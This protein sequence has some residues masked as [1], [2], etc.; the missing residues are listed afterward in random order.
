MNPVSLPCAS[1]T[2]EGSPARGS[3]TKVMTSPDP[4]P[5][6][7][8]HT[9]PPPSVRPQSGVDTLLT[10]N[11]IGATSNCWNDVWLVLRMVTRPVVGEVIP[12]EPPRGTGAALWLDGM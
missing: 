1:S 7:P 2:A 3:V 12:S 9:I 10:L 11:P 5:K 8:W 6:P 4:G